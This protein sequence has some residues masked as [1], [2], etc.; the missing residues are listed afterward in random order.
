M[1]PQYTAIAQCLQEL[2]TRTYVDKKILD[3]FVARLQNDLRLVRDDGI[4]THFCTFFTPVSIRDRKI[5][6]GHHKKSDAWIA[7]GGHIDKDEIPLQTVVR[8]TS[9]ELGYTIKDEE[10]VLFGLTHF[11]IHN[12]PTC[13]EHYDLWHLVFFDSIVPFVFDQKEFYDAGWYTIKEARAKKSL[14]EF[15]KELMILE[16]YLGWG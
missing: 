2:S 9:E 15:T 7:P 10:V 3:V 1:T 5:Y 8:E 13:T 16:K 14:P 12:R 6:I 11:T 4:S